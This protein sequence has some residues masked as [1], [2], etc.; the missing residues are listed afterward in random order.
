MKALDLPPLWLVA[1]CVVAWAW[2]WPAAWQG[3]FWPGAICLCLAAGL[4]AG[5]ATEFLRARTTIIPRRDPS[6]LI[7]GGIYRVT[8]NPI[9]LADLLILAGLSLWWGSLPGLVLVPLLGWL[10]QVRFILGEEVRLA[11]AFGEAYDA[12][13]R[14]TRRWI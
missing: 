9:Y 6:A 7:S 12:Y 8:R 14:R 4:F 5:A 2:R 1:A 10:L 3:A 13:R 11:G